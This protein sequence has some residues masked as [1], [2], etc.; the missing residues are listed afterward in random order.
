MELAVREAKAHF[1]EMIA[2]VQRGQRVVITKHGN[3]VAEVVPFRGRGGID[4]DKLADDIRQLGIEGSF[5]E[6]PDEFNDP[7]FSRQVLGLE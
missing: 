6:W 4:F 7:A 5:D 3:P 2:S 1:S